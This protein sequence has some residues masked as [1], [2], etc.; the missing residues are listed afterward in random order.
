MQQWDDT[1]LKQKKVRTTK[2]KM[3]DRTGNLKFGLTGC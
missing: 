3:D 2:S 1:S